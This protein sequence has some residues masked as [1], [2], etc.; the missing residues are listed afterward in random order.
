M[1]LV[2]QSVPSF[3]GGVS[4]QPD[5]VRFPDQVSEL[6]N[7]FPNEVEGLQKRPP[8]IHVARLDDTTPAESCKYHIINRDEHEQYILQLSSGSFK[9]WDLDGKA[10]K[11]AIEDDSSKEYITTSDPRRNLRAV[12]VADYTF[13]L[14]TEKKVDKVEGSS[15]SGHKDTALVYIK[16][17]QYAKTYAIYIDNKYICGVITPDGGEPKQAVQ[18]TTAYIAQGLYKLL[19]GTQSTNVGGTYDDLIGQIGGRKDMGYSRS[20]VSVDAYTFE[21]VGDST[22]TIRRKD[23]GEVPNV[24]VKDG[25]GNQNALAYMGKV[26]AINK[27]PP[28]ASDGYIMEVSGE[29]KSDEDNFF[30]KWDDHHKVW[31][32][33]VAPA[34]PYKINPKNMPHAIV[35]EADGTFRLKELKWVERGAGD[36]D[37]NPDPSFI[38]RP[39]N[40]I[41]FYRNRL[42]M[43]AD[44]SVI[45]SATNDFFNFWYKS[46]TVIADTDPID[47]S[48][49]SNKVAILTHA[50]PFARELM[51]FSKEGQFVLSSDGVMTPKSVKCDQITN[52][53]Y[54]TR[55]QPISI[56]PSIFFVNDRVNYTSVMRYYSLQ[57]AAEL[58]DADDVTAHVPTYI[59]NGVIAL[60]G[61]TTE[62]V[63]TAINKYETNTVYCYKYILQGGQS[64][65]QAWF[66]WT[67]GDNETEVCSAE[68]INSTLYLVMNTPTGLF[69]EKSQL[70][71]NSLDFNEEP[72]RLFMDRKVKYKIPEDAPYDDFNDRTS[73][74]LTNIYGSIP[75]QINRKYYVVTTDGYVQEA[76]K[77]NE[78]GYFEVRGDLRGTEVFIG[79][80]YKFYVKLSQ[81]TVRQTL[82]N[83]AVISDDVGRLV[84][85]Y[86][87]FNY[88]ESGVFNCI[89]ENDFKHNRYEYTYT[90]RLVG[91]SKN[92]LGISN[93]HT[94]KF[95][96]PV[97]DTNTEVTISIE[98]DNP[99]PLN[100]L[101]GGWEGTYIKRSVSI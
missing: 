93:V 24:T 67:Y 85:R 76:T 79:E 8:T 54:S 14:N 61:N 22:I 68:F 84:L 3:K 96:F 58:K 72:V 92:L 31:K 15:P 55:V 43:V 7:G 78:E 74:S 100:I 97:Q 66:K 17:A 41:F 26:S 21:Q 65:Q 38:D 63:V 19:K 1:A 98:S 20:S 11:V 91:H 75:N 95:K 82:Q 5:I 49:S 99:Q 71:G 81:Q 69:L 47:V 83:G 51:L 39:I 53:V 56:G 42:G 89:V 25:F 60:S 73:I 70:I 45:L 50:I 57:D 87:W 80:A 52:F 23:G 64:L 27:L 37:T 34:I 2:S 86:Y 44:E 40:D 28:V 10:R 4:Q 94:G 30:V 90:G 62:C 13:I 18:T 88:S 59:P 6:I 35:R 33:C 101:S 12:T 9:V 48:V 32:E 29:K 36:E 46:A 77:W 16:N